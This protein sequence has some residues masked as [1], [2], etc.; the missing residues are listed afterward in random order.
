MTYLTLHVAHPAR[1]RRRTRVRFLVDSG[2]TYSFVPEKILRRLGI[3]PTGVQEFEL[4]N[5]EAITRARGTALFYHGSDEGAS[6]VV[7]AREGDSTLLGV[8]TLECLGKALDPVRRKLVPLKLIV[9]GA[10]AKPDRIM[11]HPDPA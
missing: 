10:G 5:G 3:K 2:A 7:F 1:P 4:A 11:A 6:P 9:A 8:V